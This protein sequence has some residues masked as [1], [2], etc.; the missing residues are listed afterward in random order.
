M[1]VGR[2]VFNTLSEVSVNGA[3]LFPGE[4]FMVDY[5]STSLPSIENGENLIFMESVNL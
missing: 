1:L 3:I 4:W 5:K 2:K